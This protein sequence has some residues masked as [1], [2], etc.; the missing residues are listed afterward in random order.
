MNIDYDR[1]FRLVYMI[2]HNEGKSRV[3]GS[4]VI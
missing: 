1:F 2:R 4:G 3:R